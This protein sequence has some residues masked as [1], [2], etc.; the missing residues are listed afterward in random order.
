MSRHFFFPATL[1][2]QPSK[3]ALRLEMSYFRVLATAETLLLPFFVRPPRRKCSFCCFIAFSRGGNAVFLFFYFSAAAEMI[4]LLF[5]TRPPWRKAVFRRF[6]TFIHGRWTVFYVFLHF[7]PRMTNDFRS[8]LRFVGRRRTFSGDFCIS[9][10][11]DGWFLLF[12]AF[13]RPTMSVFLS[14]SCFGAPR[15]SAFQIFRASGL[16]ESLFFK[17]LRLRDSPTVHFHKKQLVGASRNTVFLNFYLSG[18][19]EAQFFPFFA[20]RLQAKRCFCQFSKKNTSDELFSS[21]FVHRL[22]AKCCFWQFLMKNYERRAVF[23]R[24]SLVACKRNA[25][26]GNF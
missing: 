22:Q 20:R 8:I 25:V 10:T 26:F 23:H 16:P 24:I 4:F 11:D 9:S 17:I 18:C 14:F 5:F 19:P 15:E 7:H 1:R 13:R 2:F 6:L 3:C 12:F 21:F